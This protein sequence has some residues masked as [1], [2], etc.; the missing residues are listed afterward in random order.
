M[1]WSIIKSL[2]EDAR[3]VTGLLAMQAATLFIAVTA[4]A[5]V[6]TGAVVRRLI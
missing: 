1:D 4:L 3:K 2:T 5:L 6:V